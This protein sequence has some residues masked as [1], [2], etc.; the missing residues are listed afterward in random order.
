MPPLE[1]STAWT[2]ALPGPQSSEWACFPQSRGVRLRALPQQIP[3]ASR[4][5]GHTLTQWA[6]TLEERPQGSGWTATAAVRS[7][8]VWEPGPHG[9]TAQGGDSRPLG[10]THHKSA[11]DN[12]SSRDTLQG[13]E[14]SR[15]CQLHDTCSRAFTAVT[16]ASAPP[17]HRGGHRGLG[18]LSMYTQPGCM[19]NSLAQSLLKLPAPWLARTTCA[20]QASW[21]GL[22]QSWSPCL[23]LLG[24]RPLLCSGWFSHLSPS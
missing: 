23:D 13:L 3:C 21:L 16:A 2:T 12:A 8:R 7:L 9:H 14:G 6:Q 5:G 18:K 17:F 4:P 20:I 15:W 10:N 11:C 1:H 22:A 19:Q 24:A